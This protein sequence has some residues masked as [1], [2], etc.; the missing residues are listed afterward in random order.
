MLSEGR[1]KEKIKGFVR[2]LI[3]ISVGR[4]VFVVES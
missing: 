1:G 4:R 3:E 2:R